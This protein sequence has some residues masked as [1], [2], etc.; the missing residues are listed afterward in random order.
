[1]YVITGAT[2]NTGTVAAKRL[3]AQGKKV[4]VIGRSADRLQ[5][6]ATAGAEPFVAELSDAASLAKAFAGAEAVYVMIPPNPAS[7]DPLADRERIADALVSALKTSGV[8]HAVSLS[9]VGADKPDKTGPVVGLHQ[10]EEKLNLVPGLNTLHLRAGYF[11]ENTLGQAG[12]IKMFGTTGGPLKPDLKLPFIAT[13]DVGEA[14]AAALLKQ[15]FTGHQTRELLGQRDL[16]MAEIAAII[17]KGI[18]KPGLG[19]MQLPNMAVKPAFLQLGMS[20]AVADLILEMSDAMNSGHMCALETRCAAN[21]T[22]TSYE[23]FVAKV[24]VPAYQGKA[25]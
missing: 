15:D 2:G 20:G 5:P 19:Y 1:M 12:A 9:S 18:G 11:M 17:G 3:L 21:T 25:A 6:L 10:L 8:K 24:F 7:T 23:E 14:A 4:R 22:S 13:Q 16:S